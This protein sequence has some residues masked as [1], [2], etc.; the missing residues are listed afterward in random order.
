M[1]L[2]RPLLVAT[3]PWGLFACA[4]HDSPPQSPQA[5]SP[6][7]PVTYVGTREPFAA[8]SVY[9]VMTD[10]FV[11]GDPGNDHRD[12]GGA[13][14]SFD[15]PLRGPDG[16]PLVDDKGV[17]DNLGYLG[18]DFKGVL[19]NA[20]YIREM[21]FT[22]VWV[23]PIVDN[24]D[25][26]FTGGEAPTWTSILTDRGK[27]GYH[28]YWGTNFYQLDEHLGSP[29]LDFAGFTRGMR[30]QQLDVVLDIVCNHGSPGWS[31]PTKQPK[32]G[33]I[34]AADG[35][36]IADHQNLPPDKLDPAHEPLQRFFHTKPDLAQLADLDDTNPAVLDYLAGAYEQW[37]DQG[38]TAFRVDTI[39]HM[40]PAFWQ[41]FAERMRKKR[42][43]LFMFGEAFSYDAAE[44]ATYTQPSAGSYSVLDFPLKGALAKVFG[45]EHADFALLDAPLHLTQGPYRNPYEL[46]T[47]YDNH[48]MARLDA[49]D[50]GFIDAHNWLFT[51]RGI[52]AVYYGSEMG[53]MRGR[54]EHQGNR[55]YFGPEGIAAARE[56]PIRKSLTRIA[57]LRKATPALQRGLQ[58]DLELR[59]DRASFYRV[60]QDG[61]TAQIALVLLNKGD[62]PA[63]FSVSELIEPG[64]WR[65]ALGSASKRIER[66]EALTVTV[67]PHDVA[68]FVRDGAVQ[69]ADLAQR[70]ASSTP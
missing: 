53:F 59:G 33:Q 3:L 54:A 51:A 36:L 30:E 42:P 65:D 5:T 22:A 45:R 11:N 50:A 63:E 40:P 26:A 70:L 41:K 15:Q 34:F 10:R 44:I 62:A 29:G 6:T 38:A 32:F 19:D 67:A 18:G 61:A 24:P 39:S 49:D 48:D 12:Q 28:G 46:V 60:L 64:D 7:P 56:H 68:V 23:T 31:M 14:P 1:S 27:S 69:R 8:E 52:P 17:G 9:F 57:N 58:L 55:N 25:E 43:G 20:A 2:S 16:K 21:G 13:H 47:F 66:G 35:T 4:Q 37:L